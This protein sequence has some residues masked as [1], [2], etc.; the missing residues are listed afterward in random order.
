[1]ASRSA[2]S[3][4]PASTSTPEDTIILPLSPP[5]SS[6]QGQQQLRRKPLPVHANPRQ[7]GPIHP[8]SPLSIEGDIEQ[9]TSI[10]HRPE[11]PQ[12]PSLVD[13]DAFI[14]VPR[15]P[16]RYAQHFPI[17]E[18]HHSAS[19]TRSSLQKK[20]KNKTLIYLPPTPPDHRF[21][22]RLWP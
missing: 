15:N 22:V 6:S 3:G 11:S 8:S 4:S 1:M 21:F 13:G 12:S 19:P 17:N 5:G 16:N 14:S 18:K 7:S 20:K 10:P 9:P 2:T